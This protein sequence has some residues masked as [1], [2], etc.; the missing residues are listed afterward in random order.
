MSPP[1]PHPLFRRGIRISSFVIKEMIEILRQPRLILTLILGPFLILLVFGIGYTGA[2]PPIHGLLVV[3]DL[4]QATAIMNPEDIIQRFGS[5]MPMQIRHELEPALDEVRTGKV[6]IV[7]ALPANPLG[8]LMTGQPISIS[9]Y[10]NEVNPLREG[11]VRYIGNFVVA[12]VNKEFNLRL[13]EQARNYTGPLKEFKSNALN[14]LLAASKDI[15]ENRIPDTIQRLQTIE[16]SSQLALDNLDRLLRENP[17]LLSL[18]AATLPGENEAQV[19]AQVQ[20]TQKT[21]QDTHNL[22]HELRV[23]LE[24]EAPN[25]P[26]YRE[27]I[28]QLNQTLDKLETVT[29]LLDL[30]PATVL[31][32]PLRVVVTNVARFAPTYLNFYAPA[33]LALLLQHIAITFAALALVRM[34][35]QGA[36]E[37]FRVTPISAAEILTGEYLSYIILTLIIGVALVAALVFLLHVPLIGNLLWLGALMLLLILASLGWGFFI[38]LISPQESQAVQLAMLILLSSVFFGNF[39][40][41]LDQLAP[42]VKPLSYALPV[43]YAIPNLQSVML[44]GKSPDMPLVNGMAAMAAGLYIANLIIYSYRYHRE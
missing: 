20:Q 29:G 41:P 6:E 3:P 28:I 26:R 1:R 16:L 34:R 17:S 8:L 2:Q 5:F 12:E 33:V 44:V 13:I 22:A 11:Y 23:G 31:V 14:E 25:I 7:M 9:M 10:I 15:D 39:F 27:G 19:A 35:L 4:G 21:L 18:L 30:I 43:T 42:L 40:F 36:E 37:W 32:A 38:S 24:Q